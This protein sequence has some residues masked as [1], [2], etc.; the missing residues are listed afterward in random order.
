MVVY[1]SNKC[2]DIKYDNTLELTTCDNTN[3]DQKWTLYYNKLKSVSTGKCA[4]TKD[5]INYL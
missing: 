5:N 3:N 2:L 1:P 4:Y